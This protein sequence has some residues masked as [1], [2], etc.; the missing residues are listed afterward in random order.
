MEKR[1]INA[2]AV[3][4][5]ASAAL[6]S[7]KGGG[8]LVK[9]HPFMTAAGAAGTYYGAKNISD[10]VK[11]GDS[12]STPLKDFA[13]GTLQGSLLPA[14]MIAAGAP[15]L[16]FPATAPIGAG[17]M[18]MGTSWLPWSAVDGLMEMSAGNEQRRDLREQLAALKANPNT[19]PHLNYAAAGLT[20]LAGLAGANMLTSRLPWLK[21][22]KRLRTILN[23][24][25]A[26]GA[27]AAGYY[28]ANA[29]QKTDLRRLYNNIKV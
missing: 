23:A 24:A 6:K 1:A 4:N 16:L 9:A 11:A 7:A 27:G 25:L 17:M 21:K 5:I 26:A 3:R 15:L 29:A 22:H 12:V 19:N 10:A 13:R 2:L 18:G 8:R 28:G 20:G 14:G